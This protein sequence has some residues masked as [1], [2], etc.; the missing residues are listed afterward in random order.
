MKATQH[1]A[2]SIVLPV[3]Q[4]ERFLEAAVAS[5]R[6]Q[7]WTDWELVVVDDGST[8]ASASLIERLVQIDQRIRLIRHESNRGLAAALN[9]GIRSS[10]APLL[11]ILEQ[12]D[13]WRADKLRAQLDIFETNPAIDVVMVAQ[14]LYDRHSGRF[15]GLSRGNL[16][17]TSFRQS[18]ADAMG[19]FD[20]SRELLGVQDVDMA[21]AVAEARAAGRLPPNGHREI[22]EP[23]TVRQLHGT[24]E[25]SSGQWGR[26]AMKY[27]AL[28]A[29]YEGGPGAPLPV[30][31]PLLDYVRLRLAFNLA[32]LGQRS[33]ALRLLATCSR[34]RHLDGSALGVLTF[35]LLPRGFASRVFTWHERRGRARGA[36]A[37]ERTVRARWPEALAEADELLQAAQHS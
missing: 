4:G 28:L 25:S 7:T 8:D 22:A 24:S 12:D 27:R 16:S 10:Q 37:V 19:P 35:I 6:A 23:Q 13:L 9:T 34:R 17:S 29:R 32:A 30:L 11:A 20:E 33:E 26:T 31:V 1:P 2:I 18:V 3:Y 14:L 5:V 15:T 36:R 21:L